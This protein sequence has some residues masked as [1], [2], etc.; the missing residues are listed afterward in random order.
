MLKNWIMLY[1]PI[2]YVI[3]YPMQIKT[4]IM[5]L[6]SYS[7]CIGDFCLNTVIS[8]DFHN[9]SQSNLSFASWFTVSHNLHQAIVTY[10]HFVFIP[11]SSSFHYPYWYTNL[12]HVSYIFT[13]Y[14]AL[15][16][17]KQWQITIIHSMYCKIFVSVT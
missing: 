15:V 17:F 16:Y 9:S 13:V 12:H 3:C 14:S 8:T 5:C 2:S 11:N 6:F 1:N 4:R 7:L 10:P